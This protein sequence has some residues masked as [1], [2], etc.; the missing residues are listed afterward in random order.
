MHESF[1]DPEQDTFLAFLHLN[2]LNGVSCSKESQF[3]KFTG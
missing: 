3:Y 2:D 1:R